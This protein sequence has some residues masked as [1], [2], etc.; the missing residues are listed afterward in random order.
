[1]TSGPPPADAA[2]DPRCSAVESLLRMD[3]H[4]EADALART[5]V[6][7]P[8]V[9]GDAVVWLAEAYVEAGCGDQGLR[10]MTAGAVR[11]V[12]AVQDGGTSDALDWLLRTRAH[13]RA[14]RGLAPDAYDLLA[15]EPVL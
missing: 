10:V 14:A 4:A 2:P 13:L 8:C 11:L 3:R 7:D 15:D 9:G 5:L 12:R 1:M 6:E